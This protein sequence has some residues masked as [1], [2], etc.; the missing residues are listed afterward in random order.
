MQTL[1]RITRDDDGSISGYID[2]TE[3]YS[4]TV[5]VNAF[6]YLKQFDPSL[7][8]KAER[9]EGIHPAL[10]KSLITWRRE[11]SHSLGVPPFL[12]LHQRVLCA[13]ADVAPQTEEELLAIYG[14][15]PYKMKQF[16]SEILQLTT[17]PVI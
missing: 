1:L 10:A 7:R 3:T 17:A 8:R 2:K 9:Y 6:K 4:E 15:G 14:F 13:I 12:I 5:F 16:G 11:K